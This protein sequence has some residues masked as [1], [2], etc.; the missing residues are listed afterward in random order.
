MTETNPPANPPSEP[1]APDNNLERC[2]VNTQTGH[3]PESALMEEFLASEIFV[4]LDR[5]LGADGKLGGSAA[6]LIL[7]ND[8]GLPVLAMFTAPKRASPWAER[9]AAYGY[10]LLTPFKQ[11]LEGF[12]KGIGVVINP[13]WEYGLEMSPT[14]IEQLKARANAGAAP[15]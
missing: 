4:L 14:Y 8:A 6:P 1:F 11:L 9:Y 10:G 13:G 3:Y 7:T 2:L 15:K 5:E 12:D